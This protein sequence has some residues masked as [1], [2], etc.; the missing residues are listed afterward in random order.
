MNNTQVTWRAVPQ[1]LRCQAATALTAG[2]GVLLILSGAPGQAKAAVSGQRLSAKM[3]LATNAV[4]PG[5]AAR[6]A[7]VAEIA[8]GYHINA[9]IPSLDYLI[10]TELKFTAGKQ[11]DVTGISY[12]KGKLQRLSF[13]PQGLSVYEG[14]LVIP[15]LLKV[16]SGVGPGDYTLQGT[17][18]F[19]A[20]NENSCFPPAT[21]A[22]AMPIRVVRG[23]VRLR[24]V[25]ADVFGK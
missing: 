20:C 11:F 17:I 13:A 12:P 25:N 18:S 4:H 1:F 21:V 2:I 23:N 14:R 5:A 3:V 15:A 10:P 22:F 16:A 6:A 24:P 7:V 9:H 19:Q 8:P